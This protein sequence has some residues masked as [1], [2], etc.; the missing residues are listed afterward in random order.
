M[1][2]VHTAGLLLPLLVPSSALSKQEPPSILS[3]PQQDKP[4]AIKFICK[5]AV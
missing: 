4:E 5:T 1:H 3:S 2:C